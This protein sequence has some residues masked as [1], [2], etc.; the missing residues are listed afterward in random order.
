MDSLQQMIPA[1]CIDLAK[2]SLR[3]WHAPRNIR[4]AI[5]DAQRSSMLATADAK[6]TGSRNR[7][8][9]TANEVLLRREATTGSSGLREKHSWNSIRSA[10][11]VRAKGSLR[12]RKW[13]IT[14][15]RTKAIPCFSGINLIGK[16]YAPHAIPE[17]RQWATAGGDR[18]ISLCRRGKVFRA[19]VIC[20]CS[21][22]KA[23]STAG[24]WG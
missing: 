19:G 16:V 8:S 12:L 9:M 5:R 10:L 1:G 21:S 4:A 22:R 15:F 23:A 14:S 18:C 13:W 11:R 24:R 2:W 6:S 7:G 17:R 3:K 20:S